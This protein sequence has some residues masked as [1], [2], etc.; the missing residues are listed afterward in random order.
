MITRSDIVHGR[1]AV[2]EEPL[3]NLKQLYKLQSVSLWCMKKILED[4][5]YLTFHDKGE[6][7][8]YLAALDHRR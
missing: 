8:S 2:N 6:R 5:V 4:K 3:E 1:I 7:D